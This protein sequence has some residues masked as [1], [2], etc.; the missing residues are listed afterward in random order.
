VSSME[1]S[2]HSGPVWTLA[3]I[4]LAGSVVSTIGFVMSERRAG[5]HIGAVLGGSATTV[6][7][8]GLVVSAIA[9]YA[10][11]RSRDDQ[12]ELLRA[13]RVAAKGAAL[14]LDAKQTHQVRELLETAAEDVARGTSVERSKL[15]LCLIVMR[16][17]DGRD[18]VLL[19]DGDVHKM[20]EED[21]VRFRPFMRSAAASGKT[22]VVSSE[23]GVAIVV[24]LHSMAES[25]GFGAL[26]LSSREL[27]LIDGQIEE[28]ISTLINWG[29]LA[30]LMLGVY[31]TDSAGQSA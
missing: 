9:W 26:V 21:R 25:E 23:D 24:P 6:V 18:E 2:G 20:N 22:K 10:S 27:S 12:A 3:L 19:C 13:A 1:R 14:N 17:I 31:A 29:R 4:S 8:A 11:R 15:A 28:I 30:T 7:F 5:A 16:M